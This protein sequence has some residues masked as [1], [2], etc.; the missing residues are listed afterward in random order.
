MFAK[1]GIFGK[2]EWLEV[3]RHKLQP[4]IMDRADLT[5][6]HH[7]RKKFARLFLDFFKPYFNLIA[8]IPTNMA[9]DIGLTIPFYHSGSIRSALSTTIGTATG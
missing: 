4:F 1:R 7:R 8:L 9:T 5:V 3:E 6:Y 2:T